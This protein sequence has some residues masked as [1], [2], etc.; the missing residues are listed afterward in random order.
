MKFHI[1]GFLL[2]A[3]ILSGCA[4][5][6]SLAPPVDSE[7]V[8]VTIKVPPELIP[9]ALEVMYRSEICKYFTRGG[10]GQRVELDGYHAVTTSLVRREQTD[11][12]QARLPKDGGGRCQ[13]HLA[14]IT[15]GVAYPEANRF[16]EGVKYGAGGGVVVKFDKNRASR[17]GLSQKV[18]GDLILKKDFYPWISE[19]FLGGHRKAIH[20]RGD[21][22]IYD[23]YEAPRASVIYFE[24]VLHSDYLSYV[25]QPRV[26]KPGNH[27]IITYPDGS[28][29]ADGRRWGPDFRKLQA[30][31][32]KADG[33]E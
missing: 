22:G 33:K 32:L 1:S 5:D 20:I 8:T 15:F 17:D 31:R 14:N 19:R 4:K 3:C 16:G 11:F 26:K 10:S 24:P 29:Q 13:W 2:S 12:Y 28:I 25:V 21:G 18:E 6:H 30:I 27:A 9:E 7:T 23:S